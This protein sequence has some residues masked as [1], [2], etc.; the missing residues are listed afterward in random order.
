MF[1]DRQRLPSLA[2][3][4]CKNLLLPAGREQ[5][6]HDTDRLCAQLWDGVS[7][8]AGNELVELITPI[9]EA[10]TAAGTYAALS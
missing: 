2:G 7:D 10:M 1:Y 8:A 6:E 5:I 4:Q 3:G 9:N